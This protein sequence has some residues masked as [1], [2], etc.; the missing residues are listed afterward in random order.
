LLL[1]RQ[2]L[3]AL[4]LA[5]LLLATRYAGVAPQPI[6]ENIAASTAPCVAVALAALAVVLLPSEEAALRLATTTN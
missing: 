4:L 1:L 6:G 5:L 3:L 2:L